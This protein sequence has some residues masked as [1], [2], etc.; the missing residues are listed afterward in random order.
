[1]DA[2]S[3]RYAK[4]DIFDGYKPGAP[5]GSIAKSLG[6]LARAAPPEYMGFFRSSTA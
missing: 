1:M 6:S 4:S 5:K 3:W 2:G